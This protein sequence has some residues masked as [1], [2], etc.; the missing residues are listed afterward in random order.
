MERIRFF[1]SASSV[2]PAKNIAPPTLA[3]T[4]SAKVV[5][6]AA[7]LNLWQWILAR[8]F[9]VRQYRIPAAKIGSR[10]CTAFRLV[11]TAIMET[12]NVHCTQLSRLQVFC[13]AADVAKL[14][15][16]ASVIVC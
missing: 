6:T 3:M 1:V 12:S 11:I 4:T 7:A 5:P 13:N 2:A 10:T 16:N 9:D 8:R 15:K 14:M